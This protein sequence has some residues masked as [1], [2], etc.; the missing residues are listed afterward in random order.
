[1]TAEMQILPLLILVRI[2]YIMLNYIHG[3]ILHGALMQSQKL[4]SSLLYKIH[5]RLQTICEQNSQHH[6]IV[7]ADTLHA[8]WLVCCN[9]FDLTER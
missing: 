7:H 8:M 1:M 6:S 2:M 5:R 4:V 9:H 3:S